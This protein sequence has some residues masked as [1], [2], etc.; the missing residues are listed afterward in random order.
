MRPA[1]DAAFARRREDRTEL[2]AL[3]R[4]PVAFA[5]EDEAAFRANAAA[6]S[7]WEAQPPGY[8][9]NITDWLTS[10]KRPETRARRLAALIE[11]SAAGARLE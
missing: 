3:E 7:F 6:W 4:G 10:A 5:P 1:G 8:R 11:R 9:R 2:P